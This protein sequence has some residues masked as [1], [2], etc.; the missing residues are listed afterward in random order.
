MLLYANKCKDGNL[1]KKTKFLI[2]KEFSTTV[3]LIKT[4]K[5]LF[6]VL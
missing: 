1:L 5:T 6:L 2:K 4:S 3:Y